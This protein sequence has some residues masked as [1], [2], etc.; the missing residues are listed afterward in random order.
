MCFVICRKGYQTIMA[1]LKSIWQYFCPTQK[2]QEK[3]MSTSTETMPEKR[4]TDGTLPEHIKEVSIAMD[5]CDIAYSYTL[6]QCV[7]FLYCAF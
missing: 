4:T 2:W 5:K 7:Y 6:V 1:A 3:Q